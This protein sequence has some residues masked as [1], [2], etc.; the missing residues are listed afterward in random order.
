MKRF[1]NCIYFI[2]ALLAACAGSPTPIPDS[3]SMGAM[4]YAKKCST[5]HSTPHPKRHRYTEW[6]IIV[7]VM[8][9]AYAGESIAAINR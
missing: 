9:V 8:E 2:S 5:C 6:K 3:E 4:L 1:L 7:E